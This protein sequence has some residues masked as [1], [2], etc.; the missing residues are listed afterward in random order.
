[1]IAENENYCA[2]VESIGVCKYGTLIPP[3]LWYD[4]VAL[5]LN[6]TTGL[7]YKVKELRLIGERIVNL[8]RAFNVREGLTRKDDQLPERLLKDP[9]PKGPAKGQVVELDQMLDEY[10]QIRG[11]DMKTGIPTYE[12]LIKVGLEDVAKDLSTRGFIK[13][14]P[15]IRENPQNPRHPRAIPK[16]KTSFSLSH[17]PF[18]EPLHQMLYFISTAWIT[19]PIIELLWIV[20]EVV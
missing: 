13:N 11:W 6:L 15:L 7:K 14:L 2:L 17:F 5:A 9:S 20:L 19:D 12:T 8:N 3:T 10:Y 1:M 18:L 4:D 16:I